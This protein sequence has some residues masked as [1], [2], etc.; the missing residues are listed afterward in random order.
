M[1]P[2][3]N[4]EP[5]PMAATRA[6]GGCSETEPKINVGKKVMR[7]LSRIFDSA[8]SDMNIAMQTSVC[9]IIFDPW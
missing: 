8:H 4:D 1:I 7:D 6:S 3:R 2:N 5:D 9:Q